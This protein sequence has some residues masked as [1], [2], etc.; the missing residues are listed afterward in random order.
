MTK[1][2]TNV[3]PTN[4]S[5]SKTHQVSFQTGFANGRIGVSSSD[6]DIDWCVC[7]EILSTANERL[8]DMIL[9]IQG[10]KADTSEHTLAQR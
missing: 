1:H 3:T 7:I 4:I 6:L 10:Y 2:Q 8:L 5:T 9:I